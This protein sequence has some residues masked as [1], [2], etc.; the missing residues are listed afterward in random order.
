MSLRVNK[1]MHMHAIRY[2]FRLQPQSAARSWLAGGGIVGF[3]AS[4]GWVST[5]PAGAVRLSAVRFT[6]GV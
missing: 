3:F 5:L 1:N 6:H 2:V 4:L